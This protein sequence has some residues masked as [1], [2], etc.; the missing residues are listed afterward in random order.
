ML[1]PATLQVQQWKEMLQDEWIASDFVH[2][3]NLVCHCFFLNCAL[4]CQA[5]KRIHTLG[6]ECSH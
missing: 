5:V 1:S 2:I 6:T 3:L 4:N